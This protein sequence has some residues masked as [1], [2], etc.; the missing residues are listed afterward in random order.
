MNL[1]YLYQSLPVPKNLSSCAPVI[2][3][4]VGLYSERSSSREWN[5][6]DKMELLHTVASSKTGPR[7]SILI[8]RLFS[9]ECP[10]LAL[11]LESTALAKTICSFHGLTQCKSSCIIKFL[12]MLDLASYIYLLFR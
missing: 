9:H 5:Y 2:L 4:E 11:V 6:Q 8:T 1:D 12:L 7:R 3:Q 10:K